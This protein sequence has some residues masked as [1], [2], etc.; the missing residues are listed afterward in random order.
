MNIQETATKL[1]LSPRHIRRLIASGAIPARK[2]KKVIEVEVWEISEDVA[3]AAD[4]TFAE[5]VTND[6]FGEWMLKV[7]SE[8]GMTMKDLSKSTRISIYSLLDIARSPGHPDADIE[9]NIG[10][11]LM[12]ADIERRCKQAHRRKTT[13]EEKI[14]GYLRK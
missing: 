6:N 8:T 12:R 3:K 10:K 14:N 4:D 9:E 13:T 7:M 1:Q 11:I 5:M 2:V